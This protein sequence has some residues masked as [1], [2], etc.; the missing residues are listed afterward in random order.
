MS[1]LLLVEDDPILGRSLT[2]YLDL[3]GYKVEWARD[4]RSGQ[5]ANEKIPFDLVILDVNLPDG[6]GLDLC[7]TIRAKGS[8]VPII[9]LTAKT[10]VDSVVAGFTAGAND[11]VKKPFGN[12]ELLARIK[13]SLKE[14]TRRDT[15]MRFGDLLLLID[16]RQAFAKEKELDLNRREFDILSVLMMQSEAVVTRDGLLQALDKDGEIFDRTIDSH[17]SH[18]RTKLKKA[19]LDTI[20]ISSVYGVGY[21]LE[22]K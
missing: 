6:S 21:R 3:E 7:Q 9:F 11:Y 5:V 22:K 16:K 1:Q 13:A 4:L 20:Q 10:D 17:V 8:R 19:E 15:Q 18:I 2:V 12:R 14:T